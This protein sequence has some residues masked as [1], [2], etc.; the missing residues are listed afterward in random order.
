M[1]DSAECEVKNLDLGSH[2]LDFE[3]AVRDRPGL[4]YQLIHAGPTDRPITLIVDVDPVSGAR[5]PAVDSDAEADESVVHGRSHDEIEIAGVEP[6]H[7]P[8]IRRIKE[9][10]LRPDRPVTDQGPLVQ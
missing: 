9:R 6:V 4:P 10:G 3:Q 7:N 5:D 1:Q 8:P 2:K